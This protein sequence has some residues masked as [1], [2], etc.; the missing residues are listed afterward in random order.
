M[1][2]L[3]TLSYCKKDPEV[4]QVDVVTHDETPYNFQTGSFPVPEFNGNT[5]TIEG[6]KLGRMLFYEKSMSKD[7]TQ[8]CASC[9][10][11]KFAF[12]D[13]ARFSI[14]VEG[15]PGGRQAMSVFN[16]AWHTNEFF[17]T[18]ELIY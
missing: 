18:V 16:T 11:Q 13:T 17:W 15:K 6:V 1:A 12:T 4:T 14:G 3:L 7:I 8:S 5:P 9:H 2:A 10:I